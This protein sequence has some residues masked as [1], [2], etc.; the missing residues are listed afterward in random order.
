MRSKQNFSNVNLAH[1]YQ[2]KNALKKHVRHIMSDFL[3]YM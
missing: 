3:T 2:V 1:T